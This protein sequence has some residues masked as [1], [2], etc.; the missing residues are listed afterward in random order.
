M[1]VYEE[2]EGKRTMWKKGAEKLTQINGTPPRLM[3]PS[4]QPRV[5]ATLVACTLLYFHHKTLH[6]FSY[7]IPREEETFLMAI[8]DHLPFCKHNLLIPISM[9]YLTVFYL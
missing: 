6:V 8:M 3:T 5:A 2:E 1:C 4:H 9:P 7:R